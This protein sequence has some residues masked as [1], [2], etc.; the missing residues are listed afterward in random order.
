[1]NIRMDTPTG[2]RS[3]PRPMPPQS[4]AETGHDLEFLV[5]LLVKTIYRLNLERP[6]GM[7]RAIRLPLS[8]TEQLIAAATEKKLLEMKGQLGA[9]LTAEMKYAL[10]MRGREWAMG[11]LAINEW[12]GPVPVPVDHFIRQARKQSI[13]HETLTRP[14]L[15]KQFESL[16]LAESLM[17]QIGPAVNSGQSMLL[18]GPP[19]NGKS[20][21]AEAICAAYEDYVFIPFALE[22]DKQVLSMFDPTV[23]TML[24]ES[25]SASD[26]NAL[27]QDTAFDDRYVMCKRPIVMVGGELT[28]SQLDL[29]YN[30][31][32]RLYEA[33]IQLKAAGGILVV[34]DFGRQRQ[35]PQDLINRLII[36]LEKNVDFL[37]LQTG[38]KFEVPFDALMVFSTNINPKELVDGAALRR[39]R[40]KILVDSPDLETYVDI[41]ANTARRF[42]IELT[43]D[44][45]SFV[46]FELYPSEEGAKYQAFHP[47]F[48]IEQV[49][50]ICAYEQVTPHLNRDYLRRAWR[51]LFTEH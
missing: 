41:F 5:D 14:M 42:G 25:A 46:L 18:Y 10:T 28:L 36:P 47:R 32:S 19:G 27:R 33:P 11:A 2:A 31:I 3:V 49:L 34:D 40:Y 39:L 51:N 21:I 44:T 22:I 13:R 6:S 1:M 30:P 17:H 24:A 45:V 9:S 35:A 12:V 50:A 8:L 23:H 7:A 43:E 4:L 48:L 20:S 29:A 37:T 16:T 38:R 26:P 15:E